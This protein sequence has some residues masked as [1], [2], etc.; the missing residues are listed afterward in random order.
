PVKARLPYGKSNLLLDLQKLQKNPIFCISVDILQN[1]NFFKAFTALTNVPSI[2][3]QQFWNTL[4]QEAKSSVYS[5]QL[6]EQ[7]FPLN[8]E[9][10]REALEIT[11]MHANS[12]YQPWRA[13]LT[14]I[15]QCFTGKTSRND[16]PRHPVLQMLWGIITKSNVDYAELL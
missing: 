6:D 12:L 1:T 4:T 16:K 7:W 10:L 11:P 15:N 2:Y 5:F 3:I 8:V 9:L 13:M 14:L